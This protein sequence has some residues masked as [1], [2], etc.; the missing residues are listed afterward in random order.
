ME[1][2][3]GSNSFLSEVSGTNL[4]TGR[5]CAESPVGDALTAG[6]RVQ[7][8][9]GGQARQAVD[10]RGGGHSF[11]GG[12]HSHEAGQTF[13][14]WS[15]DS[16]GRGLAHRRSLNRLLHLCTVHHVLLGDGGDARSRESYCGALTRRRRRNWR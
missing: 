3:Y 16:P 4:A 1:S 14:L 5:G 11:G 12:Q 7:R 10:L 15:A 13:S 8:G 2:F 6:L 9:V